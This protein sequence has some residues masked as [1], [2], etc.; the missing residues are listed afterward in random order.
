MVF[1]WS[2]VFNCCML[3]LLEFLNI[4]DF[5]MGTLNII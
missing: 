2:T 1:T 5:A 3:S 4:H